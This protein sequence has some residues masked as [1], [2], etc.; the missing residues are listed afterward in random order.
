M[1]GEFDS[2]DEDEKERELERERE[3]EEVCRATRVSWLLVSVVI[4][5]FIFKFPLPGLFLFLPL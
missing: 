5:D 1:I 3:R 4:P 2:N